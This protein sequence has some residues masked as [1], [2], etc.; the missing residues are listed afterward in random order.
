MNRKSVPVSVSVAMIVVH[1][2]SYEILGQLNNVAGFI[3]TS[4]WI[5]F[6]Q[7]D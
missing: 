5:M 4:K 6:D 7:A 2:D 1:G 3:Y